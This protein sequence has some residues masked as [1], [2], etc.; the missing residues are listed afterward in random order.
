M[1]DDMTSSRTRDVGRDAATIV[2]MLAAANGATVVQLAEL[3]GVSRAAI[4]ARL[5]GETRFTLS[6]L[7]TLAEHF[8]VDPGIF[9]Q[10]PRQLLGAKRSS[11]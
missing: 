6:D 3:I 1:L 10:D 8:E 2:G 11:P 9:F 5:A 4:Y 7:A